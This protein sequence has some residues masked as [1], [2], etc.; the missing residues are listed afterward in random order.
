MIVG[1][2]LLATNLLVHKLFGWAAKDGIRAWVQDLPFFVA[3]FLIVLVADL[4]QYWTH[5]AY[6]EVPVLWRLHAVHHSVKSM[7]WLAGSR[8]HILELIITR[9]LVLA[10]IF[11]LGFS[12][13]VIDAYIVI[14]GFQA[15]FNHANVSVRLGPLRYVIVTPNFHHWHH[16]RTP[17]AST[18]TTRRISPSSTTPSAPRTRPTA[19]GRTTTA[20]SATTCR[21]ASSSSSRSRSS[22]RAERG[23]APA[24]G[25]TS[26]SS[27]PAPPGCTARRSPASSAA[28][29][30]CSTTPRRSP[31]RSAS[32]AA[33]A[34]TSPTSTSARATSTRRIPTSAARR[35][36]ATRRATSSTSSSATASPGTRSTRGSCSATARARRSSP[37]CSPSAT[38]AACSAGSRAGSRR[39]ASAPAASS[40]TPRAGR[41][42]AARLVVATGGLS[43]PKIGASDWGYASR[44]SSATAIV[45]PRP[46]LVPFVCDGRRWQPFAA[47]AGVALPVRV[48]RRRGA[49]APAFVDD[50]LFTH[51]GLSGPAA[52]QVSTYWRPG[53]AIAVD[54]APGVDLR[55]ALAE[56]KARSRRLGTVLA[57]LAAAPARRRLAR[58]TPGARRPPGGRP[59]RPRPGRA[60]R[61][62]CT[63]GRRRRRAPRATARPRSPP[64]A[65]TPATSTR[66]AAKAALVPGL[67]FIGEVVDVTGWLGGYNFQWAWASAAACAR[68]H[69]GALLAPGVAGYNRSS[70][71]NTRPDLA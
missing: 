47:L 53:E 2:V 39:S 12:K 62:A 29:S 59:A 54:L 22:G 49:R 45:E 55:R 38:P 13:E 6:H 51:R 30:S 46:A 25:S 11:V 27:A 63:A 28:R 60:R 52:L 67:H 34:A 66:A 64:A 43:I 9:T 70:S 69:G 41:C 44:A 7:D 65:S 33:A 8:Q 50:L 24:C 15:V 32:R 40:S 14:V 71:P 31:R 42:E 23:G 35:W 17:R 37:C 19:P 3:L 61:R 56:A 10:P 36:R 57:E 5:R 18:A 4:V 58:A 26:P 21:T 68:A 16:S 20:W 48:A 1:F